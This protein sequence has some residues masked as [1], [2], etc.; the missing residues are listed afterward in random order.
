M[1]IAIVTGASSGIGREFAIQIAKKYASEIDEMWLIARREELLNSLAQEI[2]DLDTCAAVAM[3]MD[4]TDDGQMELLQKKIDSENHIVKYLV[5][6]AGMAK[7]GGPFT[8]DRQDL[9][10]MID[11]NCKAAINMTAIC[12][13]FCQAGS[14]ILQV[15]STSAFQPMQG[16][17]VYAASKA[18]LLRYSQ[19][20]SWELLGKHIHVT[21]VCPYWVKNT[22]FISVAKDT[23]NEKGSKA[24]RHF[25]LAFGPGIVVKWA[26]V[27]N[28]IG[29]WVS[30]PGPICIAHRIFCKFFPTLAPMG[31]WELLRRV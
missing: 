8:I 21:A 30:T 9:L 31:V 12:L 3:P 2:S 1:N 23:G 7:I 27:D 24:V 6:A 20:L 5:N 10:Q 18:L 16:L 26:L 19:A 28:R 15:C 14:H 13:P 29:F 4:I 22:E 25:P 11:L 17:N